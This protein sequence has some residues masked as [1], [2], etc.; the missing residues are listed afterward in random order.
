MSV[1]PSNT[2]KA[3]DASNSAAL[4]C[5]NAL[6]EG[7]MRKS[8]LDWRHYPTV[9]RIANMAAHD[10]GRGSETLMTYSR[11]DLFRAA[12]HL[13]SGREGRSG[14]SGLPARALVV[15]G[16]FIPQADRPAAETDGPLGALEVCM[17]LRAIGGD[18]WLVSDECCE[19]V[20]RPAALGFLP[21]DHVL[22]APNVSDS[23]ESDTCTP[24]GTPFD[25]WLNRVIDLVRAEGISTLIYIERVGPARDGSP[26]NMRGIDITEWTAPLSQL[27][28]MSLH[29][30]G[31]G[32]GGNE[33]G[34]GRVEDYAI[35]G[36]VDH[37]AN[38]ACTVPTDQL[39]VAGTSNWGAHALVCA[40]RTFG[41]TEVDPYMEIGWQRMV[42]DAI[43]AHGGLDGVHM[44]NVA[45]VDGLD[46]DRY[47]AEIATL[48]SVARR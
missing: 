43:V 12:R 16:F 34:M 23:P 47:F 36:V 45:T 28:L 46:S 9:A 40:M 18:A 11:G 2:A 29:T 13:V 14:R 19:P 39:V 15:T 24:G 30:I 42:L 32:D 17:A 7:N 3:W 6:E 27:T 35:E 25:A 21:E 10:V 20:I 31:V 44:T 41:R 26:H 22:I 5:A 8:I 48:A 33:I 1:I 38:I 37:G 4:S